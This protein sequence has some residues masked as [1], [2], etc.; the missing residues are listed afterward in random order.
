MTDN[1]D[2]HF[3]SMATFAKV[4]FVASAIITLGIVG[5]IIWLVVWI[6]SRLT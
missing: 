5:G 6:V 1:F 2:R 4:A 3:K